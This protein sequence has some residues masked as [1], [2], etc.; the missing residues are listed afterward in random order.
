MDQERQ[1]RFLYPPI[2]VL[3]YF[4]WGFH[5]DNLGIQTIDQIIGLI[6][7][8][9]PYAGTLSAILAGGTLLVLIGFLLGTLTYAFARMTFFA[10]G[11]CFKKNARLS[12]THEVWLEQDSEEKIWNA[13]M[14]SSVFRRHDILY[15]TVWLDH[16]LA[17]KEIHS[18]VVRRWNAF[19]VSLNI[20]FGIVV[21]ML[22]FFCPYSPLAS[23]TIPQ[24]WYNTGITTTL[25]FSLN[26][27]RAYRETLRMIVFSAE[28]ITKDRLI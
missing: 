15:A 5:Y 25:V 3:C 14:P 11:I 24:Y 26:A 13:V 10:L 1:I 18:W 19:N 16:N 22:L 12:G 7:A 4:I 2:I 28:K 21:S 6:K 9:Q 23:C 8:L 20:C 27:F 17:G